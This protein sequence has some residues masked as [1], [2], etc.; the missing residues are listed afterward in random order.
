MPARLLFTLSHKARMLTVLPVQELPD[1]MALD[2]RIKYKERKDAPVCAL[3]HIAPG[4]SSLISM[5]ILSK[6]ELIEN[7]LKGVFC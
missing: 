2:K 5:I 3:S 1:I 6:Y 4:A 7:P